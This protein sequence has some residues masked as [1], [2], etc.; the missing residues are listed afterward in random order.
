[1]MNV[2]DFLDSIDDELGNFATVDRDFFVKE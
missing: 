2:W 1:M